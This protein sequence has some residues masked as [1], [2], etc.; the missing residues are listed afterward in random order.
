MV[1]RGGE[2]WSTMQ[3]VAASDV[4]KPCLAFF[5]SLPLSSPSKPLFSPFIR[6]TASV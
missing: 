5:I 1:V 6:G 3:D 4:Y 2:V